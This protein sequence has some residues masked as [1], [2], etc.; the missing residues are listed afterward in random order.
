MVPTLAS[1]GEK[2]RKE[3]EQR[4][5][6]LEDV[7][8]TTR[9]S[10][11]M[12][13]AMEEDHFDQLPGGVFNKGFIRAYAKHVGIDPEQ[14]VTDY[15]AAIGQTPAKPK[16]DTPL[17]HKLTPAAIEESQASEYNDGSLHVPWGLV[18]IVLLVLVLV[19]A[20]WSYR[21]RIKLDGPSSRAKSAAN[22]LA[23]PAD[24]ASQTP[25]VTKLPAT[26]LEP[27][28]PA[29][30]PTQ[31]SSP[32]PAASAPGA[33]ITLLLRASEDS[34]LLITT[35]GKTA[36]EEVLSAASEKS[37]TAGRQIIVKAGNVGGVTFTLNG[38]QLPRQGDFG[39]VKTL[40]FDN[41]GVKVIPPVPSPLSP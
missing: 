30:A 10:A 19:F 28:A 6:T 41:G 3:R 23:T 36:P 18:A 13:R 39:E 38:K 15:L 25:A 22:L 16:D 20:F 24:R 31:G 9:I 37:I 33:S 5:I 2:L 21:S 35:D 11:R 40:S 26:P 27:S 17:D 12:L 29:F 14:A 32:V 1:F 4:G 7:S 8:S 34:W